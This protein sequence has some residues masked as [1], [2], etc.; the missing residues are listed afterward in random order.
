MK[1][2]SRPQP[3]GPGDVL[4]LRALFALLVLLLIVALPAFAIWRA[5]AYD[6]LG[7]PITQPI[8]FSHKHHVGDDG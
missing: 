4:A 8:P 5:Q 7:Q 6:R 1:T 3:F 2:S